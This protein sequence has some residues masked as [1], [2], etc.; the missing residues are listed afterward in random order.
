MPR[1][2]LLTLL[3]VGFGCTQTPSIS[4][5]HGG[6]GTIVDNGGDFVDCGDGAD[7]VSGILST[8]YVLTLGSADR[9]PA[10]TDSADYLARLKR[11]VDAKLP[12]WS[13]EFANYL[14]ALDSNDPNATRIWR[15]SPEPL[16]DLANDDPVRLYPTQ[17][18]KPNR[19]QEPNLI[20]AVRR[21]YY[22]DALV[23]KLIYETDAA[24]LDTIRLQSPLQYSFLIFHEWLWD[25]TH[26]PYANRWINRLFH[27]E[28][29]ESMTP[30][31]VRAYLAGYGVFGESGNWL[32][33]EGDALPALLQSVRSDSACDPDNA[34]GIAINL[35][36]ERVELSSG[37]K[38]VFPQELKLNQSRPLC[39]IA[40]LF[41]TAGRAGMLLV[42]VSRGGLNERFTVATDT[43]RQ[44]SKTGLCSD[45]H[46]LRRSGSLAFLFDPD[47]GTTEKLNL[48]LGIEN[49]GSQPAQLAVPYLIAFGFR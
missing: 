29:I 27:D 25:H 46:C 19:P 44:H 31:E 9:L 47:D 13:V 21:R 26:S 22:L 32:G 5:L 37:E 43:D 14:A 23:P 16:T 4:E 33:T 34:Q 41:H 1:S 2:I 30:A 38:A 39:G 35:A 8:D 24:L 17:C 7:L 11:L 10:S 40:L 12:E 18:R 6:G 49:I 45:T 15:Q 28:R 20:Q 42:K 48:T 36:A 3:A